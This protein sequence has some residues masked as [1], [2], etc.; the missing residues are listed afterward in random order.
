MANNDTKTKNPME[1]MS[2]SELVKE[3]RTGNKK[4]CLMLKDDNKSDNNKGK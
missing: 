1:K 2:K 3:C 4:A